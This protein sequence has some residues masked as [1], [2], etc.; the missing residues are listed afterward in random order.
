MRIAR[1]N[2]I[3]FR[4]FFQSRSHQANRRYARGAHCIYYVRDDLKFKSAVTANE[5]RMVRPG[6]ENASYKHMLT[7]QG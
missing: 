3:C 5:G 7:I 4:L 2:L 6:L 1:G